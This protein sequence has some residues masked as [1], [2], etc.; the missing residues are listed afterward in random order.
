MLGFLEEV[1]GPGMLFS[2]AEEREGRNWYLPGSRDVSVH[3]VL[4]RSL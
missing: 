4:P 1:S 2:E 3:V